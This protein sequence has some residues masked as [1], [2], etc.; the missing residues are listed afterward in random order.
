[1]EEKGKP[2]TNICLLCQSREKLQQ[3]YKKKKSQLELGLIYSI[4]TK[5]STFGEKQQDKGKSFRLPRVADSGK[6]SQ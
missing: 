1:M 4:L 3:Q 5:N 6:A 2:F